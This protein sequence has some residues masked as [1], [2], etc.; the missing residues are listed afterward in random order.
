MPT[1]NAQ[2]LTIGRKTRF[3]P[4]SGVGVTVGVVVGVGV[5]DGVV[6]GVGVPVG[7]VVGG[8]SGGG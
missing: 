1:F 8:L 4:S 5:T 2:R 7:V 6:V 3:V